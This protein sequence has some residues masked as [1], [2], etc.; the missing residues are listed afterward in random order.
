[1]KSRTV[2]GCSTGGR[3][4]TSASAYSAC[5][6]AEPPPV[7]NDC[8]VCA[9]SWIT[10]SPSMRPGQPRSSASS[11]GVNMQS[12]TLDPRWLIRSRLGVN[13]HVG[14][15]GP[16]ASDPLL[17]LARPCVR[18]V[19][20]GRAV[21]PEREERDEPA[22]VRRNRSS[23]G[24][25]P[26]AARTIAHGDRA[27]SASTSSR[28]ARLRRAAR[29]ASG[30]R[31]SPARPRRSPPRAAR[32][33]RAP[34]RAS[35]SPG[36]LTCSESSV[37]PSTSTSARL[38]TS[39]TCGTP[40]AAACARSRR[41]ASSSGS[42]WTTTS[43]SGSA[44]LDGRLDR[45][46]GCMAL[47]DRRARRD[48]DHDVGELAAAGLAHPQPPQLDRRPQRVDRS[49][50]GRFGLGGRTVHQHVDV[51]L[52]Q[53]RRGREHEHADEE[54]RDRVAVRVTRRG[55]AAARRARRASRRSRC[56]SAGRSRRAP[57]SRSAATCAT[58]R[59]RG[60]G[61]SRCTTPST[62][63]AYHGV[64]HMPVR[65]AGEPLDR[66]DRDEDAVRARGSR[67]RRAPRGARPCRA[68]TG[69]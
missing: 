67:P 19:E 31:R 6:R 59:S 45:V 49:E 2:G 48:A 52:D 41:S 10:R 15:V 17:D 47:A 66:A 37:L 58:T 56:R 29:G 55:Q 27:P 18:L 12:F 53:P 62:A 24:S 65:H 50:R 26:V 61:R 8:S 35:S 30:R 69:A 68:R 4:S 7:K 25:P 51:D 9:A 5:S 40:I 20:A 13:D 23:R 11:L 28:L 60:S 33:W 36:S 32:R 54:R 46:G 1:M 16:F 57:R 44:P 42:T 39:R 22:V 43:A 14:D 3:R 34:P 38:C 63:N 21:E 64:L